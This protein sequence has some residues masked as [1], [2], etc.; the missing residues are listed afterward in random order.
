VNLLL[1]SPQL[2]A[3]LSHKDMLKFVKSK[4][5]PKNKRSLEK[6]WEKPSQNERVPYKKFGSQISM[7]QT[8]G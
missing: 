5:H 8:S 7:S 6:I 2:R 4:I 3:S 1:I